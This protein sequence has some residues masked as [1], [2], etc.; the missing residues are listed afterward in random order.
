MKN[1][2]KWIYY[3]V[4]LVGLILFVPVA[5]GCTEKSDQENTFIELL[6]L[7]PASAKE[8]G[9]FALINYKLLRQ[10]NGISLY[11]LDN[12]RIS[13]GDFLEAILSMDREG[14][15]V[16]ITALSFSSYYTG[17]D[18]YMFVSSIQDEYIGYNITDIDAEIN[19]INIRP[20]DI[21]TDNETAD[22]PD[23]LIAAI[24]NF[25]PQATEDA[26]KNRDEWPSWAVDNY[27]SENYNDITIYSWGDGS[28]THLMSKFSPPHLD[29]AGRARP[30]AVSNKHLF[31]SDSIAQIRAMIDAT[32][33]ETHSLAD[34]PEYTMA[35]KGMYDLGVYVAIIADEAMAEAYSEYAESYTG[36]RLK[37]FLTFSTGP[38]IDENGTYIA[39][40]L[41]HDTP[42]RANENVLLLE[43]LI[44]AS[45]EEWDGHTWS[46]SDFIYD[47]QIHTEGEVLLSKLYTEDE[48]LWYSWFFD[49]L[50]LVPHEH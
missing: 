19:N 11:T 33:N 13:R 10:A 9:G 1:I 45:L 29:N 49:R 12:H 24:G 40:V 31:V 8:S 50:P 6:K 23:L 32:Q 46:W 41:V 15:L 21:P 25:N 43:Q 16:D 4:I 38:G 26:F 48:K 30:L 27:T 7:L 44:E 17:W 18:R 39:L 34:I 20:F 47:I 3:A 2:G 35:V 37:K 36:P 22:E 42:D 28:V 5:G 14:R